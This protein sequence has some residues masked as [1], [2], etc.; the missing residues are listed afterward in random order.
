MGCKFVPAIWSR[1]KNTL[2]ERGRSCKKCYDKETN[3]VYEYHGCY[4][5]G[6]PKCFTDREDINKHN[7]SSYENLYKLV[8]DKVI[9][10]W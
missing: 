8:N 1:S 9:I 5:H 4:W 7:G 10:W 2:T 3:T 6:C